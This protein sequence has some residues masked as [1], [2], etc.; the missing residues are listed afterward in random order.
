MSGRRFGEVAEPR[1]QESDALSETTSRILDL[2][3]Y[4]QM[5]RTRMWTVVAMAT[6]VAAI[7]GAYVA[8]R[9][10]M[11]FSQ[12]K[13]IVDP[14]V[15]PAITG[16]AGNPTSLQPDMVIEGE[17]VRSIDI[18][19]AV[20]DS[21]GLSTSPEQ[22]AKTVRIEPVRDAAVMFIG[23]L[24]SEPE[25]A[26]T[27]ANS[28]AEEYLAARREQILTSVDAAIT[29]LQDRIEELSSTAGEIERDIQ[30]GDNPEEIGRLRATLEGVQ[31]EIN[32]LATDIAEIRG[33]ATSS[34][35]GRIV[36]FAAAPVKPSGPSLALASILGFIVGS[37]IGAGLAVVFGLRANQVGGRDELAEFL[38][39]PV[40]GVIPSV[41]GWA[42]RDKA[43]LV[44]RDEPGGPAAE[45]Y[46]TLATNLRFLR[47]QR[48]VGVVVVTSAL[49][50]EGKSATTANLAVVLAETGVRTLLVDADLRRPRAERFLG[51]PF[52]AGL[53]EVLAATSTLDDVVLSTEVPNLS[54]IRS[55][56]MPDDP[57]SLL[58]GPHADSVFHDLRRLAD[59]VICD[60]P[61]TLPVADA[62]IL[63]EAADVV[64]FVHDPAISSRTALEDAVRQLRTAGAEIAGGVYNNVTTLQRSSLGYANYDQ[65]YGPDERS[66]PPHRPKPSSE[67]RTTRRPA[68][69]PGAPVVPVGIGK[70]SPATAE[71]PAKGAER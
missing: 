24:A 60:A 44:S 57:V 53:H 42:N 52:G 1:D 18:A 37:F 8:L 5:I 41:E 71:T 68:T 30:A 48:A 35:G 36:Q 32:G 40:M 54:I 27:I 4:W 38:G 62:S 9:P 25:T 45:A 69:A 59:I 17:I 6:I 19:T 39:A 61:P 65:Y 15:N 43:E 63:A 33:N 51:V 13:V 23:Y 14:L 26:A 22:L 16:V 64:L 3:D 20:R 58:A 12:A 11:Y 70:G 7:A 55:G 34:P 50:S 28:F 49:P 21:L 67:V 29:P 10:P 56:P 31:A 66:K 2:R 46:R 47:S